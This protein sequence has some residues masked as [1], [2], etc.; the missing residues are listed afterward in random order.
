MA[1][2]EKRSESYRITASGGY[3]IEG[4]QIRKRMTW[5]PVPG[6]TE[7]Q[8]QKELNRQATLF[9]ERVKNGL[10]LDASVRFYEFSDL[11]IKEYAEKQLAPRTV[12]SYRFYL[13]RL[14][15][16]IGHIRLDKLQPHHIMQFYNSLEEKDVRADVKYKS[17]VNLASALKDKHLTH[18]MTR[19]VRQ[20]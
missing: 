17:A 5:A 19:E 16:G 1:T 4:R 6:M 13:K 9:E 20:C 3:D 10:Y 14:T 18:T 7:R 11:W 12:E 2:I 8:L 15:Q